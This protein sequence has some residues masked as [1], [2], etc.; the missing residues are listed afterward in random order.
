MSW[1]VVVV[2][3]LPHCGK[4]HNK[5]TWSRSLQVMPLPQRLTGRSLLFPCLRHIPQMLKVALGHAPAS[6]TAPRSLP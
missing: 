5:A 2:I 3:P 6:D 1:A 4:Q